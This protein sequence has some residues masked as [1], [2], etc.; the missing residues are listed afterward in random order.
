MLFW[1]GGLAPG[2]DLGPSDQGTA[3]STLDY[4][5]LHLGEMNFYPFCLT[6]YYLEGSVIF[7]QALFLTDMVSKLSMEPNGLK[8]LGF[9][10]LC[11]LPAI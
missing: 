10:G 4:L 11:D 8:S 6:H 9:K 2:K 1:N 7:T 5:Y 3:L